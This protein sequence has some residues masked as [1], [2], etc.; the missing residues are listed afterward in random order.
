MKDRRELVSEWPEIAF[1]YYVLARAARHC[2]YW[3]P[4]A[5]CAHFA[6]ELMLKFLLVLEKPWPPVPPWPGRAR[7]LTP[8]EVPHTHDLMELWSRFDA[9]WPGNHLAAHTNFVKE[10]NR[11]DVG[12]RY[13]ELFASGP[14]VFCRTIEDAEVVRAANPSGNQ[15]VLVLDM[16]R[17]DAFSHALLDFAGISRTLRGSKFMVKDCREFYEAAN[18]HAIR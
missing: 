7:P 11:W 9:A 6:V 4:A 12:M 13:A 14:T 8:A 1:Q 18:Q 15:D 16:E 17:L 10:L 3:Y 5:S 2:D